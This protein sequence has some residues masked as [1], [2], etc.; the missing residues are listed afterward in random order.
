MLVLLFSVSAIVL[1][2]ISVLVRAAGSLRWER[3]MATALR[4][5]CCRGMR[6]ART[7]QQGC[8]DDGRSQAWMGIKYKAMGRVM[9][10]VLPTD[11][12]IGMSVVVGIPVGHAQVSHSGKR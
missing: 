7:Q 12:E 10:R 3:V 8:M 11:A 9:A 6:G 5:R 1:V 4:D 2:L